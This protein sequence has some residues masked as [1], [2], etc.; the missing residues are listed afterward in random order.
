[1]RV[2]TNNP[3]KINGLEGYGLKI[4][5][6]IPLATEPTQFNLRYLETKREKLGHVFHE[7]ASA[8]S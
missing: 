5:E 4:L 6:W 1:M 7:A 8:K 2:M 3:R